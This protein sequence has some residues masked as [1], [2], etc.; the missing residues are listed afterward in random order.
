MGNE[1]YQ[2]SFND[3]VDSTHLF[4]ARARS[5]LRVCLEGQLLDVP[6]LEELRKNFLRFSTDDEE[7]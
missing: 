5:R 4:I 3:R 2:P 1:P 7:A 6:L